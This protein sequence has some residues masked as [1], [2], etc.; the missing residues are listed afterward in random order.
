MLR[1]QALDFLGEP[2]TGPRTKLS[3]TTLSSSRGKVVLSQL[4]FLHLGSRL[5]QAN[6]FQLFINCYQI[7]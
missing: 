2:S 6:N 5:F 1:G 7:L 4:V 3:W